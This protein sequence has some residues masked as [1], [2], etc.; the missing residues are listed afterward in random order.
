LLEI[1]ES[2]VVGKQGVEALCEDGIVSTPQF[3]AVV[4]GATTERGHEIAGRSPGRFAMETL[5]EAIRGL[6]PDAGAA[7]AVRELSRALADALAR[8]GIQPGALASA[9]I[10]IVSGRRRE[11]WRVGNSSFVID[12]TEYPQHWSLVDIPSRMR[13]AYLQALLR[14]GATTVE[15]VADHD[16]GAEL[17]APLLRIERVFRNR[18]DAGDLVYAAIDGREVPE[19]LIERVALRAGAEVVFL[20]DGYP[21]LAPTLAE[22]EAYLERSLAEDPLRIDRHPE[23]RGVS[24]GYVS[25]DDRSYVRFRVS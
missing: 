10:L 13:S 16:P 5:T 20:S 2:L 15:A 14:A 9:C 18:P 24:R 12:G 17:I 8:H 21:V 19:A 22:A 25:Y 1:V 23:V 3:V 6:D 11:V 7:F 4:D